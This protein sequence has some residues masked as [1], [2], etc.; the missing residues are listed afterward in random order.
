MIHIFAFMFSILKYLFI[1]I[2]HVL[3]CIA[4][5]IY[6]TH[7]EKGLRS[8]VTFSL[9][10]VFLGACLLC[11]SSVSLILVLQICLF[12]SSLGPMEFVSS[13]LPTCSVLQY[14]SPFTGELK[15]RLFV[16]KRHIDLNSTGCPKTLTQILRNGETA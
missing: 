14:S 9:V 10:F 16:L 5:F 6:L 3:H 13:S 1:T 2:N 8:S 11:I 4:S 7:I 15:M 12:P